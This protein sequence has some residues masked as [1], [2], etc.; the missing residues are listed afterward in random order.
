MCVREGGGGWT[1]GQ[2]D[3]GSVF[4]SC[5][6]PWDWV[7][8]LSSCQLSFCSRAVVSLFLCALR[9]MCVNVLMC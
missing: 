5:F 6:H 9:T 1:D 8:F 3:R 7:V 2:T 4:E